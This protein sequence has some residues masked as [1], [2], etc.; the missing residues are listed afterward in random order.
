[1][2]Y[3]WSITSG[4]AIKE[5]Q[6]LLVN[7]YSQ[8]ITIDGGM[9]KNTAQAIN[10]ASKKGDLLN[11][12]SE[13]R[14]EYYKKGADAGWFSDDYSKGLDNRVTKCLNYEL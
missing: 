1:M 10:E 2:V 14:R 6:K 8:T 9:G 5:I 11:R 13:I 3:D 7:E 4:G 12:I